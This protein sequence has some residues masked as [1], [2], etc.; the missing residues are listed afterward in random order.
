[1]RA[2]LGVLDRQSLEDLVRQRAPLAR[3]LGIPVVQAH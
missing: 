2:F 3:L 1:M